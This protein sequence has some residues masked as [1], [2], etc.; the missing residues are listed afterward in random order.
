MSVSLPSGVVSLIQQNVLQRVFQENL[1][2]RLLYRSEAVPEL[3]AAQLGE[4]RTFTRPGLMSRVT[5]PLV[6]GVDPTPKTYGFEQWSATASQYGDAID[7]HMPTSSVSLASLFLRNIQELGK[8]AGLSTNGL[9]R[10]ELFRSY[11]GGNTVVTAAA[12]LGATSIHVASI[13]GF[14]EKL[15]NGQPTPVS[16]LNPLSIT[17]SASAAA[18]TVT[19]AVP[20]DANVP[21]G[22]GTLT[23][24][25]GL[26]AAIAAR[27]GVFAANRSRVT[28]AGASTTVDGIDAADT[29]ALQ[30]IINSVASMRSNNVPPCSDG[31]YHVH[32]TAEGEAQL[33]ADPQ[34]RQLFQSLPDSM[35]FRDLAIG[36]LIG[37]RFYRNTENPNVMNVTNLVSTGTQALASGD[38]GG[39]LVNNNGVSLKYVMILGG[40]ALYEPYID[41]SRYISEAGVTGKIGEFSIINGG[42]QVM[43]D[44]IRLTI[45]S[46]QDRLQQMVSAAWSWSGDFAV[47]SDELVGSA[48][49]FKRGCVIVHA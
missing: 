22:P 35:A 27:V 49:R 15:L 11:L 28:Y 13:S 25:A 7:T 39:E 5:T 42:V 43:T 37:C 48:A 9:A 3:W 41:E 24:G 19:G 17:F 20:D 23:L 31:Y 29:L 45:R 8:G 47:P 10:D 32:V 36:Q 30:D 6:P 16:A 18:N 12:I 44:R 26:S 38:I 34:F 1:Y 14:T 21:F 40:G 2:P 33:Y 46:P 4:T